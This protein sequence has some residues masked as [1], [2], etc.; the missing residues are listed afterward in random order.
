M[1][2]NI[3]KYIKI[4]ILKYRKEAFKNYG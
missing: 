1:D 2:I 3:N 4:E